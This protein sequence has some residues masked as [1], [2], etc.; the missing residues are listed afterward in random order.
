MDPHSVVREER[1]STRTEC[2]T[3]RT[4]A[5][6]D[7]TRLTAVRLLVTIVTVPPL[8]YFLSVSLYMIGCRLLHQL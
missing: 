4:T 3:C 7:P 5:E 1:V 8:L 2:A 6:T